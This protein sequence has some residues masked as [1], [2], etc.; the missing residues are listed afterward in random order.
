MNSISKLTRHYNAFFEQSNNNLPE[1]NDSHSQTSETIKTTIVVSDY[2]IHGHGVQ[3]NTSFIVPENV[4][5]RFYVKEG[6]LFDDSWMKTVREGTPPPLLPRFA[7]FE[8]TEFKSAEVCPD[9]HL[10]YP[11][12][13]CIDFSVDEQTDIITEMVVQ[14]SKNNLM[15]PLGKGK[16]MKKPTDE[17]RT[18]SW[19]I[20]E[21]Q[22]KHFGEITV[23]WCACREETNMSLQ[24]WTRNQIGKGSLRKRIIPTPC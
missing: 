16:L 6:K 13:L 18:L 17:T 12:G 15:L 14:S 8:R 7:D 22:K 2:F 3:A 1:S 9:Y 19:I 23:H 4:S 5:I 24:E 21:L 10:M 11:T 20:A